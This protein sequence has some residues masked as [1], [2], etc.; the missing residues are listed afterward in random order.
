MKS[1][2]NTF[3]NNLNVEYRFHCEHE[4]KID[5]DFGRFGGGLYGIIYTH[6]SQNQ[7]KEPEYHKCSIGK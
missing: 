1:I 4:F 6:A 5:F 7:I 2:N 3:M